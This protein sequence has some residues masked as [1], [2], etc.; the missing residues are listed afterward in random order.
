ML[1]RWLSYTVMIEWEYAWTDSALVILDEWLPYRGGRLSRFDCSHVFQLL[2]RLLLVL[3]E[4]LHYQISPSFSN[5]LNL[6]FAFQ[7][8]FSKQ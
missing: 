6:I 3:F 7:R 5:T 4:K 1:D 2:L 8:C